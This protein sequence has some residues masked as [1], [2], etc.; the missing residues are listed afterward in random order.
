MKLKK[1]TDIRGDQLVKAIIN[2]WSKEYIKQVFFMENR[3]NVWQ[4]EVEFSLPKNTTPIPAATVKVYFS[5][6]DTE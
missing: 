5:V 3:V 2:E 4:Y 1:M 6:I